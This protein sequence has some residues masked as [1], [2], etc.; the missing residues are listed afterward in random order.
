LSWHVFLHLY[1]WSGWEKAFSQHITFSPFME[2]AWS[3]L[4][5]LYCRIGILDLPPSDAGAVIMR[6]A[7][8]ISGSSAFSSQS[9]QC[10]FLVY[11]SILSYLLAASLCSSWTVCSGRC[12]SLYAFLPSLLACFHS[13]V[14]SFIHQHLDFGMISVVGT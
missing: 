7:V 6:C 1:Q 5:I 2:A 11:C 3:W 13:C 4:P 10:C 12:L 9:C 8:Q 14:S